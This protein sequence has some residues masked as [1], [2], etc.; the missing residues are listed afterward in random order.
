MLSRKY[1]RHKVKKKEPL[2]LELKVQI[3]LGIIPLVIKLIE[4]I[5]N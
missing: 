5:F 1:R 2:G 3:G 4:M